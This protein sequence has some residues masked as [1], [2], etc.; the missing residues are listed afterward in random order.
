[1]TT[2]QNYTMGL[3]SGAVGLAKNENYEANVP[4]EIRK[5]MEDIEA[6]VISGEITVGTAFQ[7]STEEV[8]ALRD[9]MK[10]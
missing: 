9:E 8:A 3:D 1:M 10:P 4:E 6:K 7:M 2:D 5:E